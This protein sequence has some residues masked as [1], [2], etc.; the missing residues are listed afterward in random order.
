MNR[1]WNEL[2]INFFGKKML[3]FWIFIITKMKIEISEI[4]KWSILRDSEVFR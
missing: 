4:R 1:N 2:K 3:F